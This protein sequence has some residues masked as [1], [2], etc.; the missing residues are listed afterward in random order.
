[1]EHGRTISFDSVAITSG[2]EDFVHV[3]VDDH[4]IASGVEA[5]VA[6]TLAVDLCGGTDGYSA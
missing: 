5:R 3:N 2:V 1:M 6:E 4:G